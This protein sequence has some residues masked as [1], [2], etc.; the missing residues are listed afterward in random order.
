MILGQPQLI[1]SN[2]INSG[3]HPTETEGCF[4]QGWE[5]DGK[6]NLYGST[7]VRKGLQM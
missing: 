1:R 6:D 5:G 3:F 2:L 4:L 7:S